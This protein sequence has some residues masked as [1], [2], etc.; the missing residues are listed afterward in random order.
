MVASDGA[1]F[2]GSQG[3]LSWTIGEAI[4]ET[5]IGGS[6]KLTQGFQQRQDFLGL[7]PPPSSSYI[8]V[9]PNPFTDNLQVEID[10]AEQFIQVQIFDL[11]GRLVFKNTYS[12]T[13][14]A[15][16]VQL[17]LS[18]LLPGTYQLHIAIDTEMHSSIHS[19]IKIH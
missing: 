5:F 7:N 3:S 2:N 13:N 4:T 17:Q 6:G 11:R 15:S 9:F 1:Y 10:G 12:P 18:S 19:I 16:L 8:H 14:G